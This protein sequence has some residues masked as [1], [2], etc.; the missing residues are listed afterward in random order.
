VYGIQGRDAQGRTVAEN[1]KA[2][3]RWFVRWRVDDVLKKRTFPTKGYA[4]TFR[5]QLMR[6][7]LMAWD[8]DARG[9]PLDPARG[10]TL[11]SSDD[12]PVES[13]TTLPV[14]TPPRTIE[15]YCNDVWWPTVSPTL[16]D[17]NLLG[18]RRNMRLLIELLVYAPG[19]LRSAHPAATPGGSLLLEH[20]TADD[21]RLAL[22]AR[23]AINDRTRAAN[24]RHLAAA[25]ARGE[26]EVSLRPLQ[27]SAATVRAFYV[28]M[29]MIVKAAVQSGHVNGDPLAGVARLAPAPKPTRVTARLVPSIDEVFDLAD[30]IASLGPVVNGRPTGDRFRALVL[31]AGTLAA[32]PG[33]LVA[34]RPDLIEFGDVRAPTV[35]T[36]E[37]TEAA[38]YD[39]ETGLR[40][41]RTRSLKHRDVGESRHVPAMPETADAL[42]AHLER[43]YST[44][45][46][47]FTSPTG[48]GRLDWGNIQVVYWRPACER[49]FAGTTKAAL[50]AMPPKTLRKGAITHWL[51]S[52]ISIYL[53]SDW[54]GHSTDVAELYYAGRADAS[55]T[56]EVELLT[57]AR[58]RAQGAAQHHERAHD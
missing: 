54:A 51:D 49:V 22:V 25:L 21:L 4:R 23:R 31:A 13:S 39:T 24:D 27:A 53:A 34:H 11:E 30:A 52:G 28:T 58:T 20:L 7:K 10:S 45:D 3:V 56:K 48:R 12:A 15:S 35:V 44:H 46:R 9:W 1:D 26:N 14:G 55:Y 19:D 29:S 43:G 33:E 41:R 6:A 40:G 5:D 50:A 17:K 37:E 8:A 2:A 38:V 42:R 18:H 32:R 36:F 57:R 16:G 47:T